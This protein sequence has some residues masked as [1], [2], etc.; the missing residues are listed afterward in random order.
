MNKLIEFSKLSFRN[1]SR[2][3]TRSFLTMLGIFIGIAAIVALISLG[4]GM[5]SEI[6]GQFQNLGNDKIFIQ[7]KTSMMGI[8]GRM[9]GSQLT[10]KDV[11]FL[12]QENGVELVSFYS[13]TTA[14]ISFRDSTKYYLLTGVPTSTKEIE[15]MNSMWN[16]NILKGELLTQG[17]NHKANLGFYHSERELYSGKNLEVH[18]KF[19]IND[20]DFTAKGFYEPIG[21]SID[22]KMILIPYKA[23]EEISGIKDR[24]DFII[25]KLNDPSKTSELSDQI[26]RDL[27][28]YRGLEQGKEDFDVQTPEDLLESFNTIINIVQGVFIGIAL[29]S[30]LVGIIG[31]M[32]TM[33]TSVLER[34]KE[35]GIMKAIGAQNKD[36]AMIF[37]IESGFLGMAGGI[38]GIILGISLSTGVELISTKILGASFLKASY[39]IYL[40]LGSLLLSFAVGVVAG[41]MPAIQASKQDPTETLRDE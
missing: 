40:I 35:I 29:I 32:N 8:S 5:K 24:V 11:D 23:F 36:I 9:S 25:I 6:N 17:D 37:I 39:S 38:I 1:L 19:K 41:T 7:P 21:D 27:T 18:S 15:L 31:I 2:Q 12:K 33:Y 10:T 30:L 34:K 20:I 13:T 22:D 3:R 4:Q 28:R 16:V 26:T 14:K